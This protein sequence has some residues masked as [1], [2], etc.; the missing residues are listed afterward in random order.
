MSIAIAGFSAQAQ[1]SEQEYYEL[2]P[3]FG[4]FRYLQ[5]ITHSGFHIYTGEAL[6]EI[7]ESGYGALEVRLGW[8]TKGEYPWEAPYKGMSYG[9]G[10]YAGAIGDP[11][12]LGSPNGIYGFVDFPLN[13]DQKTTR[14]IS[15][16]VGL[17]Y[18]LNPYTP[19]NQTNDAIGSPI[20]VYF[21]IA[22]EWK[23][24]L[25]REL[26]L[27]YGLDLTHFSNGRF[28]TPNLG[29]N[30][31]GINLGLQYNWN[32]MQKEVDADLYTKRVLN[33]RPHIP[34]PTKATPRNED[35]I[36]IYYAGGSVQTNAQAGTSDRYLTSTIMAEY[37][38]QFNSMHGMTG[39]L[40]LF[41]DASLEEKFDEAS[42]WWIVGT[43][44]GYDFMFHRFTIRAQVGTYLTDDREK[45][46][47]FLRP[48]IKYDI[49]DNFYG[50]L[51]LKTLDGG[52]SDWVE[53][54]VG[55]RIF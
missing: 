37:Q 41:Y 13:V 21:N 16:A 34:P 22:Y 15:G 47:F 20:N 50:Q 6:E 23:T 24:K 28:A 1:L 2:D 4:Q 29:L 44:I 3:N 5:I 35:H 32:S 38:Y 25:N 8:Q 40:D 52:V 51:G 18:D 12:I 53:F 45:G 49:T 26:D 33:T 55:F 48:A 27:M 46:P 54:G 11:E 30:M 7:L 42:D 19:E 43:H 31:F 10:I 9:V 17:S 39:G 36:H 14:H